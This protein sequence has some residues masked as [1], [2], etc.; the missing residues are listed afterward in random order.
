MLC[1]CSIFWFSSSFIFYRTNKCS[2][3]WAVTALKKKRRNNSFSE[4]W[5]YFWKK[6]V[7]EWWNLQFSVVLCTAS[8]T[9]S[10][11]RSIFSFILHPTFLISTYL[12]FWDF[13]C[14]YMPSK[15]NAGWPTGW[16]LLRWM[17]AILIEF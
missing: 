1:G 10:K 2:G 17:W 9:P 12:H 14:I 4:I 3:E 11:F 8:L 15:I 7:Y 6:L 5:S 13:A 16:C